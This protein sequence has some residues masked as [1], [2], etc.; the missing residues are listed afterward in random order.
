MHESTQE[1]AAHQGVASTRE[2][3]T[4]TEVD[5]DKVSGGNSCLAGIGLGSIGG[6]IAGLGGG[7]GGSALG[8]IG[9]GIAGMSGCGFT[10]GSASGPGMIGDIVAA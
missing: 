10:N 8:V 3:T 5:A 1:D 7:P 4:A 9:G 6:G 2:T